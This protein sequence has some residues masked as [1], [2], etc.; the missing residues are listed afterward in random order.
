MRL[1][2]I[3]LCVRAE[4]GDLKAF[5]HNPRFLAASRTSPAT[6]RLHPARG[7]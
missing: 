1:N 6:M 5:L 2:V 3:A 4:G 7:L